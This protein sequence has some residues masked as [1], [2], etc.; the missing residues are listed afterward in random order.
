MGDGQK[1]KPDSRNVAQPDP[2]ELFCEVRRS[3]VGPKSN[4]GKFLIN[5][6][7]NEL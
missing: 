5:L 4:F 3:C 2:R 7:N 6:S 1:Q